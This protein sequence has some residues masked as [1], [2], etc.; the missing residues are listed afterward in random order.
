MT[1]SSSLFRAVLLLLFTSFA[2]SSVHA[3]SFVQQNSAVPTSAPQV[4][5][6]FTQAQ[7]SGDL[8]VVIV[9][10][11]DTGVSITSVTDTTGNTY[12]LAVGPTTFSG[13]QSQAI[14]FAKNISA[15]APRS[16]AVTV[17]FSAPATYPDVRALEYSGVDANSPL[18]GTAGATGSSATSDSGAVNT[19]YANDLIVGGNTVA[20]TTTSAGTGYTA[21]IITTPNGDLAEDRVVTAT[22]SYHATATLSGGGP[23]VMQAVAFR[24]AGA[25]PSPSAPGNLTALAT[26]NSQI[27]LS[28]LAASESGGTISTYLVERCLGTGC[29][30]FAQIGSSTSDTFN[31]TA[32]A[33]GTVYTYRVRAE[34]TANLLGPYSNTA[35]AT[36]QGPTTPTAPTNLVATAGTSAPVVAATQGYINSTS[37]ATHTTAAF[38]STGGDLIVLFASS[39]AGVTFTP[40]DSFGN[41]WIS[42]AGPTSTSVGFDLRSQVWYA[43]NPTVGPNHTVTMNLS[44]AQPLV[45]SVIVAKGSNI[46]SPIDA[47][48]VIGSDL[49]SESLSITSP[50]ITTAAANDLL[51]GFAKVSVGSVFQ[52]GTGYTQQTAASSN[53]L[54]AETG[55]AATTGTYNA[56]FTV[57]AQVTWQAVVAAVEPAGATTPN[58]VS[59]TWT[60]ATETGG[61]ISNYLVER[62]QGTG[63]SSF[64]QIGTS[65]IAAYSDTTVADSTIYSYRVRAEDT[66]NNLGPYSSVVTITTP[67]GGT[68]PSV[69]SLSPTSGTVGTS[70]VIAGSNF[71][72]SQGTSTVSFNG[73]VATPTSWTS[74]SITSPVPIGAT[75]GN[76]VVTVGGQAS[77]GVTFTVTLPPAPSIAS[78]SPTSGTVGTSV[79][80]A[81]SN[82]GTSQGTSTVTFNGTTATPTSWTS[83]SI[84]APVPN[85]ATSGNVAVTVGGQASNGVTFTVTLPPAPSI[86][87]LTPT[88]GM[89]GT[90]VVIAGS[91]FG[92]SQGT[93]TVTFNGTTATPSSWSST[94]ITAPVPTGAITGNVV[95][96]V[97]GQASNGVTF[98]V[99]L[100][101][102]PSI[103][104]L[105]PTSGTVGTSVVIAGSN[106]GT[107]QGT[108]TVTFN[109]TAAT[110]TSWTSSSITAPVP[111]GATSGNVVVTVGGQA[112]NGV[113]FTVTVPA[114]SIASLSPTSG[115]VGTS[116]VIAGANFGTTQGASTVKFNGTT[117]TP[118][119]WTSTSITAPVPS[120]ATS[121]NVVV[122]VGG[123]ASNGVSFTVTVPAP[124]IA[125][126]SPTSG[127]VGTVVTITGSNFGTTQ[128]ASTVKFNGT[129]ATPSN[130]TNT[131]ITAPVPTGATSGNVVVTV[132]G[133]ASNGVSF[134]VTGAPGSITHIQ[135]ASNSDVTGRT[136]T[137]YSAALPVATTAGD[138]IVIGVTYG[139][140]NPTITASDS[141]G[142]SYA[143]AIATYDSGH[144]Q[145]CA[146]LYAT[147]IKSSAT[148]TVTVNFSGAVAYLGLGVHE[149]SG[150]AISS[151]LDGTAG[152]HGVSNSPSSGSATT[153]ANGDLL[154]SCATE[155]A[156]GNG[157]TFTAGSGFTKRVDLGIP[158]AYA[159]EDRIQPLAGSVAATWTLSPSSAWIA[160]MAAFKAAP[161]AP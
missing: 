153:I 93:S 15:A 22:G 128:G 61:T 130:W 115:A 98:T 18:D 110:A 69:A 99:T 107:S 155:D 57:D 66:A 60:A 9:G 139:N 6:T 85:G 11:Q 105:T 50:N 80:I 117:A 156:I 13:Q 84:T 150:V 131:S 95:V 7:V 138:A 92:T 45:M 100:P 144:S 124:S 83:T 116:V 31:D 29:T 147:N 14:Y 133:Q 119:S 25:P 27:N 106:F 44:V 120:G 40:S 39:H 96:T 59:L 137:A 68:A 38:D 88:S 58:Q 64:S 86:A 125:S 104:S 143:L 5:V 126:L 42:M 87:S 122:T 108:S 90:F 43:R 65:P 63:C 97:G 136:Y 149:Y 141:Q 53:Y 79:V 20:T 154:F 152:N 30:N 51:V 3:Q 47:I 77:N 37:Q 75:S 123:Q 41:A 34:D 4:V 82:F 21:R 1:T 81:G 55:V 112:S 94:S 28:W 160:N 48:S 36:T 67:A 135:Q 19:L 121:G 72:T 89:V 12:T 148:D 35:T 8:N 101:P 2:A 78:L 109:G 91:N 24:A 134:M 111:S 140:V 26:S 118:T 129:A 158:A 23:W 142:N 46:S 102:A 73:T 49:G 74:T 76:V 161:A 103:A 70:V 16:N 146:I 159:D 157:D 71:G 52:P 151:T 56:T 132:G 54:D 114:P 10:W 17:T 145:G 127:Q 33:G 62:C 32:L 113:S